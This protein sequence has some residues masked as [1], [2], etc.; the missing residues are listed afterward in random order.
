MSIFTDHGLTCPVTHGL[1]TRMSRESFAASCDA[2]RTQGEPSGT[3]AGGMLFFKICRICD[4]NHQPQELE[5]TEM[6]RTKGAGACDCCGNDSGTALRKGY[7]QMLCPG[8]YT[9]HTHAK[10]RVQLVL[11]TIS[12]LHGREALA[13][14]MGEPVT[15]QS[16]CSELEHALLLSQQ[17]LEK[18]REEVDGLRKELEQYNECLTRAESAIGYYERELELSDECCTNRTNLTPALLA[19]ALDVIRGKITGLSAE[20]IEAL[21]GM[22]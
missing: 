9:I 5:T 10:N 12:K 16:D 22:A 13:E 15:Q 7:E 2:R 8:C 3:D 14:Y 20:Q 11:D 18:A 17:E 1:A 19:I 4:G 21:R 6:P